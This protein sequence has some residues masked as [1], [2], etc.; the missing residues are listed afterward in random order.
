MEPQKVLV[1]D[2]EPA[3]LKLMKFLLQREGYQVVAAKDGSEAIDAALRETPD[4]ILLD[5][6]LPDV[7]GLEVCRR[8]R[9]TADTADTPIWM[10]S[11]RTQQ[12]D[13]E[14]SLAAGA[15]QHIVKPFKPRDLAAR[16]RAHFA[17]CA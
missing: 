1:V 6:V 17:A 2:D 13:I 5:I 10:V 14:Q 12:C 3:L 9:G 16:I 8:L 11:A 4:L 15:N 7:N